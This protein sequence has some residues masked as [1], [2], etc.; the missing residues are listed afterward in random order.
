MVELQRKV[1]PKERRKISWRK[2]KK[3]RIYPTGLCDPVE[4]VEVKLADSFLSA[5][6]HCFHDNRL[7]RNFTVN[8]DARVSLP[9]TKVTDAQVCNEPRAA[10]PS[11]EKRRNSLIKFASL[12]V[13]Y[14]LHVRLNHR[15]ATA[16]PSCCGVNSTSDGVSH[17][18]SPP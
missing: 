11:T 3:G 8:H 13:E 2:E 6:Q 5:Q 16:L 10:G 9:D 7:S 17:P 1:R 18:L 12:L 15:R 14:T 4:K